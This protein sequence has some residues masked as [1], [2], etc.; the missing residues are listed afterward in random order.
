MKRNLVFYYYI[1][2]NNIPDYIYQHLFLL[3]KYK[4]IF[5]GH[6]IIFIATDDKITPIVES[7]LKSFF[8][9]LPNATLKVVKNHPENRESE[10]FIEQLE[11]LKSLD[12]DESITFYGHSKGTTYD[13]DICVLKWLVAMYYFNLE[14]LVTVE[15]NLESN[16]FSGVFRVDIPCPPWVCVDWHYSG[17]FFWFNTKKLFGLDNW[18]EFNIDRFSTESFPA[19]KCDISSGSLSE[20]LFNDYTTAMIRYPFNRY[21]LRYDGYWLGVFN[22]NVVSDERITEFHMLVDTLKIK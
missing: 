1:N 10:Y 4:D 15:K 16:L 18:S 8:N 21:D 22:N 20:D 17:T 3:E 5:N 9:F 11:L 7:I 14:T 2:I 13:T 19:T 6:C 12:N